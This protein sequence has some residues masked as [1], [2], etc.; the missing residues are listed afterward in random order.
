MK[1]IALAIGTLCLAL[2]AAWLQAQD[3][4]PAPP[5]ELEK[6]NVWIGNWTLRGTARDQPGGHEYNLRWQLR[7]HWALNGFF[8]QVDQLW[9]GNGQVLR[10]M[11]MLAYDPAK[12]IY[13]D[14]GFGSD[15]STWS[16]TANFRGSTMIETG[17]SLGPDGAITRCR[18]TWV[19]GNSGQSLSGTEDCDRNGVGWQ[20][21]EVK[22]TKSAL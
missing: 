1:R 13:T 8:M 17:N 20:A 19:F 7:E 18:M 21:I 22:G 10:A 15:G 6:L 9:E 16:L 4:R 12:A 11:E 5:P 2:A 14:S 3:R